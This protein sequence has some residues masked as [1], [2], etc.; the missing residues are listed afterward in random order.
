MAPIQFVSPATE[1][2]YIK[3]STIPDKDTAVYG[4]IANQDLDQAYEDADEALTSVKQEG[5]SDATIAAA[6]VTCAQVAICYGESD[7]AYEL[8]EAAKEKAAGSKKVQAAALNVMAQVTL[9]WSP[10]EAV[11]KAQEAVQLAK[12]TGDSNLRVCA[13]YTLA[14]AMVSSGADASEAI[15]VGHQMQSLLQGGDAVAEGCGMLCLAEIQDAVKEYTGAMGSAQ[16]AAEILGKTNDDAKKALA[17]KLAASAGLCKDEVMQSDYDTA[18]EAIDALD[19]VGNQRGQI[20]LKLDIANAKIADDKLVEAEDL[21]EEALQTAKNISDT[22]LEAESCKVL[23]TARLAIATESAKDEEV[24]VD[25]TAATEAARDALVLYRKLGDRKGEA[26]MMYKLG[27]VRYQSKAGDMARMAAEEAQSMFRD[28]G[29]MQGEAG[30]MLLIAYAMH[31]DEMLEA[32]RR[33]ATKAMNL[34]QTVGDSDGVESCADFLEKVKSSQSKKAK[35]AKEATKTVSDTG[36]VKLVSQPSDAK[37]VL[38]FLAE[39]NE[40]EDTELSEFDLS[41]WG[42]GMLEVK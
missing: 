2:F 17:I 27:Q 36:L 32:A 3:A 7:Q 15:S 16:K 21:A 22:A 14:M 40:D 23:A 5:K 19:K 4:S 9:W 10:G 13:S 39:M 30:A 34:Y 29:D 20:S 24:E 42:T 25:T 41:S 38:S 12:D 8:A 11:S 18:F 28:L 37:H 26:T 33:A 1:H 31:S 35:E 6:M